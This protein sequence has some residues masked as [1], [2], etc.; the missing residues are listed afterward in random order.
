VNGNATGTIVGQAGDPIAPFQITSFSN[1]KQAALNGL[2]FNVQHMFGNTGFGISANYTY[3]NSGLKYDNNSIGEQFALV[4]LSNSAN[5]VGIYE[6]AK[7]SIRA[8]YNW[9]G[10]FLSNTFDGVGPN[11]N[12]TEA[13]GQLDANVGYNVTE[14]LILS[15]EAINLNNGIQRIHGRTK[16]E[17]LFATQTGRRFMVGA[18]YKF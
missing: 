11:P 15:L 7:W 9:R 8:A 6:D 12:Y 4:G 5:L 1:Q 13:Y 18:R 16:S 2:E 10:E 17:V 14:K 3:V